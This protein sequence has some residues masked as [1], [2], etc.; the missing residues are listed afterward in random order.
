MPLTA[1]GEEILAAMEKEY[2]GDKGKQVFYASKNAGKISGVDS[3]TAPASTMLDAICAK[4]D[5]C[6]MDEVVS[7]LDSMT[8][9]REPNQGDRADA[10]RAPTQGDIESA[11]RGLRM[12][13]LSVGELDDLIRDHADK[14]MFA[15]RVIAIAARQM[16]S[17][18]KRMGARDSAKADSVAGELVRLRALRTELQ[19]QLDRL[20]KSEGNPA[21]AGEL[22]AKIDDIDRDI[23]KQMEG[24]AD[25]DKHPMIGKRV[26]INAPGIRGHGETGRV[27]SAREGHLQIQSAPSENTNYMIPEGKVRVVGDAVARADAERIVQSFTGQAGTVK[28]YYDPEW[29]EYRCKPFIGTPPRVLRES[30]WYFTDDK[31]DA[32]GT[33]RQMVDNPRHFA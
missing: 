11:Q 19:S 29:K 7:K 8:S 31:E 12:T 3:A 18:K 4:M 33:A 6:L 26:K 32:L 30:T 17:A 10:D 2:G 22:A 16:K 1:K 14:D 9:Y 15:S 25:A 5:A 23:A 20:L 27:L 13:S 28:V 21:K 24:K